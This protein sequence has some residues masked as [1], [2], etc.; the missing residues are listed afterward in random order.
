VPR[1]PKQG[2][3]RVR[4]RGRERGREGAEEEVTV[5]E[6]IWKKAPEE[7]DLRAASAYLSLLMPPAEARATAEKLSTAKRA[8][9][10]VK[11]LLRA[12]G[13]P[14]LPAD[15][16]N[17]H[18]H[19]VELRAEKRLSPVLLVRGDILAGRALIIADGYHRIC[20]S[21]HVDETQEIDCRIVD[22]G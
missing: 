4:R 17:V 10:Q 6:G 14:L 3:T 20:A 12:A 19:I 1:A 7:K 9:Y 18:E 15:T 16:P 22:L 2:L 13:E 11:D 21:Y 5:L 8:V